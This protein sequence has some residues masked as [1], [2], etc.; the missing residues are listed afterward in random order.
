M[1]KIS[2]ITTKITE[3][4]VFKIFALLIKP[5]LVYVDVY[6]DYRVLVSNA[7]SG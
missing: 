6:F 3:S 2:E 7:I 1:E 4:T 5:A